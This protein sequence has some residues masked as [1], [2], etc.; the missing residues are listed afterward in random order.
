[1]F[2]FLGS[3]PGIIEVIAKSIPWTIKGEASSAEYLFYMNNSN[4]HPAEQILSD[5]SNIVIHQ[6]TSKIHVDGVLQLLRC[7]R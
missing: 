2:S 4:L 7:S 6:H 1:M 3:H 5:Y